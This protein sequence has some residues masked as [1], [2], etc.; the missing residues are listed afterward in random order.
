ME[1]TNIDVATLSDAT[2]FTALRDSLEGSDDG[3]ASIPVTIADSFG[4]PPS[5]ADTML[6]RNLEE[7]E[8]T[9]KAAEAAKKVEEEAARKAAEAARKAAEE[10]ARKAAE[11]AARKAAEEEEAAE[12]ARKAAEEEE[13]RK[14]ANT[15]ASSYCNVCFGK[16]K[17]R[18]EKTSMDFYKVYNGC[19]RCNNVIKSTKSMKAKT[20]SLSHLYYCEVCESAWCASCGDTT[21][22][23]E[24][25]RKRTSRFLD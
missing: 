13:A 8:A 25:K 14:A 21:S 4:L 2:G 22:S 15:I 24:R 9:R 17:K 16:P 12:A 3:S 7:E 23:N 1:T 11:E 18:I 20:H 10:A 5:Q 19:D 6:R